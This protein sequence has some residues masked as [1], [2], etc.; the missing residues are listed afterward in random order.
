MRKGSSWIFKDRVFMTLLCLCGWIP[1]K[2]CL[3]FYK[4]HISELVKE[5]IY[6][7]LTSKLFLEIMSI[8]IGKWKLWIPKFLRSVNN[9]LIYKYGIIKEWFDRNGNLY[10]WIDN[11]NQINQYFTLKQGPIMIQ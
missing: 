9:W 8:H 6:I 1:Y 5:N 10:H 7:A 11:S 4:W 2:T 3:H